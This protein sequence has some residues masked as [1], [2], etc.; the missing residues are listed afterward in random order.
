MKMTR[1]SFRCHW[2]VKALIEDQAAFLRR[3]RDLKDKEYPELW[4]LT[5]SELWEIAKKSK[6]TTTYKWA[7]DF[8]LTEIKELMGER[9]NW[10]AE[11]KNINGVPEKSISIKTTNPKELLR[12]IFNDIHGSLFVYENG[13]GFKIKYM[14]E[15]EPFAESWC[16]IKAKR[17]R[18]TA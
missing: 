6:Q 10:Q 11:L 14:D 2:D 18:P 8:F 12:N 17:G 3:C 7:W 9:N 4:G 16:Y 5:D 13:K 1:S 15:K